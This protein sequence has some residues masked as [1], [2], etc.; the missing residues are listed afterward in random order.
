[1]KNIQLIINAAISNNPTWSK[2]DPKTTW[3]ARARKLGIEGYS[4]LLRDSFN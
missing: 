2:N 4:A 3:L 1:M